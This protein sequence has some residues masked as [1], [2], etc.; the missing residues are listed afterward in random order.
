MALSLAFVFDNAFPGVFKYDEKYDELVFIA[1]EF[2]L[3]TYP[4]NLRKIWYKYYPSLIAK[5]KKLAKV[6]DLKQ[7]TIDMDSDEAL[8]FIPM[9]LIDTKTIEDRTFHKLLEEDY[10]F[11]QL[12]ER[13]DRKHFKFNYNVEYDLDVKTPAFTGHIKDYNINFYLKN[14]LLKIKDIPKHSFSYLDIEFVIQW[15]NKYN[16]VEPF[17]EFTNEKSSSLNIPDSKVKLNDKLLLPL[18]DKICENHNSVRGNYSLVDLDL[19]HHCSM[20]YYSDF[21]FAEPLIRKYVI[22]TIISFYEKYNS[23]DKP[24]KTTEMNKIITHAQSLIES[25]VSMNYSPELETESIGELCSSMPW[26]KVINTPTLVLEL[27]KH[28]TNSTD[29]IL[30][31]FK[32][33]IGDW[34]DWMINEKL[35]NKSN[36]KSYFD[37]YYPQIPDEKKIFNKGTFCGSWI[38]TYH[39][40][41]PLEIYLSPVE[42]CGRY[43]STT[44]R[45]WSNYINSSTI[46]NEMKSMGYYNHMIANNG[47]KRNPNHTVCY[48]FFSNTDE[49]KLIFC[50]SDVELSSPA[51]L[52]YEIPVLFTDLKPFLH[53]ELET[54]DVCSFTHLTKDDWNKVAGGNDSIDVVVFSEMKNIYHDRTPLVKVF[55]HIIDNIELKFDVD[56]ISVQP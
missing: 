5:Y 21:S 15:M 44:T 29:Y 38:K 32:N 13:N 37:K 52:R 8:P 45:L 47:V 23:S 24:N 18:A 53:E 28:N 56:I 27:I 7:L 19:L 48:S 3:N 1:Q 46:P 49:N 22:E 34:F 36:F 54:N 20:V 2:K 40:E 51:K 26:S 11:L 4:V 9:S 33:Y 10:N 17:K 39:E 16:S 55:K 50:K 30:S 6:Y 25:L 14:N 12:T 31:Q 43:N 42:N 35:I 41:P